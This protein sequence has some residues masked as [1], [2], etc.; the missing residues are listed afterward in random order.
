[1]E[2]SSEGSQGPKGAVAPQ[3]KW[4]GWNMYSLATIES[5][6]KNFEMIYNTMHLV[7]SN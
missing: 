7:S 6:F 5:T 1:M 4:N 2:T 3:M